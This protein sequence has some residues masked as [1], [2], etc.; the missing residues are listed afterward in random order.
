MLNVP[1]I[2]QLQTLKS[3]YEA[4]VSSQEQD[5]LFS[6]HQLVPHHQEA[7]WLLPSS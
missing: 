6:D 5:S 4:M 1:P 7:V 3:M 2:N